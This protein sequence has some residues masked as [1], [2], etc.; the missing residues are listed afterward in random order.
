MLSCR[1]LSGTASLVSHHL[2]RPEQPLRKYHYKKQYPRHKVPTLCSQHD[3]SS[4]LF[5]F[6]FHKPSAFTANISSS[7]QSVS[8]RIVKKAHCKLPPWYCVAILS[9][10]ATFEL[11][12]DKKHF[13]ISHN[14]GCDFNGENRR[15]R[16]ISTNS[17]FRNHF[18]SW[19]V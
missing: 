18:T 19:L 6:K 12:R 7:E 2:S 3:I 9:I 5:I 10:T 4:L 14:S 11:S 13:Y 17:S 15:G 16:V 8:L 1:R